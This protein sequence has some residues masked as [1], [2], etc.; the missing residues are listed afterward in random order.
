[1]SAPLGTVLRAHSFD[2]RYTLTLMKAPQEPKRLEVGVRELRDHLSRW[3]DEVKDGHEIVITD[4]GRA[5][6][7][8]VPSSRPTRLDA[9]IER[10]IVTPPT[11]ARQAADALPSARAS[12]D[13]TGFVLEQRR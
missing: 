4:R 2:G 8:L 9:L 13:V 1:V 7:R 12:G 6:A 10:G 5:V 3:L 11:E